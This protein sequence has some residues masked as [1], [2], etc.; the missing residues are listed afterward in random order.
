M[1]RHR[2]DSVARLPLVAVVPAVFGRAANW[3]RGLLAAG[4][5]TKAMRTVASHPSRALRAP[6]S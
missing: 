4:R 3:R 1:I 2:A 6:V 5:K